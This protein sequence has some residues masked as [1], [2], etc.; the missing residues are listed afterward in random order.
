M[1]ASV[2]SYGRGAQEREAEIVPGRFAL[3]PLENQ[4]EQCRKELHGFPG[5][6]IESGPDVLLLKI[7]EDLRM[8]LYKWILPHLGK[9]VR[10]W[11]PILRDRETGLEQILTDEIL[12]HFQ[13]ELTRDQAA[14]ILGKF[15][16]V[17]LDRAVRFSPEE[18]IAS[19][20]PAMGLAA[21]RFAETLETS[22]EVEFV[23]PNFISEAW[24]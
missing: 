8:Q 13:R 9:S 1:E 17:R 12:V 16:G 20:S 6:R 11:S 19:V 7:N 5:I 23:S 2:I 14:E 15:P 18:F 24:R 21:L 3:G 22:P 4:Q 10:Y